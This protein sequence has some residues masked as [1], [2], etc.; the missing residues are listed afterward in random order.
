[1]QFYE[2]SMLSNFDLLYEGEGIMKKLTKSG[3]LLLILTC[4][5]YSGESVMLAA[6]AYIDGKIIEYAEAKQMG[7]MFRM[8]GSA[9]ILALLVYLLIAAATWSRLQFLADGVLNMRCGIMKNILQRPL[10]SF[11]GEKDAFYINLLTAD[12][13][14]YRDNALNQIPFLFC[15][16][17]AIISSAVMLWRLNIFLLLAAVVMAAVPLVVTRPFTKWEEKKMELYSE[18]SEAHM[19][20][21]KETIEGYEAIRTGCGGERFLHRYEQA[22]GM[23]QR[24]YSEREFVSTMSFETLMSVASLSSIVCMGMGGWLVVKGA[25]TAGMLF[26]AVR[27]FSSLSNHFTNAIEYAVH[28]RASKKVIAKLD[29]QRQ[30]ESLPDSG[31]TMTP[32]LEISYEHVAF[33]FGERQLYRDFS[34]CFKAGGCYAVVGESGSGKSTLVKL[35]LKYYDEYSG[36]ITLSGQDIRNIPEEE[37][38]AAVGVVDQAPYLFNASLYENITLF[39]NLPPQDSGEYCELLEKLGLKD[40]AKR[41]ENMP[42]G[43]FGDNISGGER[44]RIA[45]A[46]ALIRQ[47]QMLIFDEPAAALDP[48]TRD[49]LNELI[50]SLKGYTRIVI[51][52]DRREEYL[53]RFDG[54][55]NL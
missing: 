55:V 25:L 26:A 43:D 45:V 31:I 22:A 48:V 38:Y 16:A 53:S 13:A 37:I 2:R 34:Y 12:T 27:Y 24:G 52:H 40:L 14:L 49:S 6:I 15:S 18:K 5:F 8:I 4:L 19:N 7:M 28:I 41:V 42:L 47:P 23:L 10:G 44:Q 21:L 11:R 35:L 17:A 32:P 1:M 54:T 29:G 50:F 33:A 30:V 36:S 39:G 9:V 3:K 20:T 51:T 46:R